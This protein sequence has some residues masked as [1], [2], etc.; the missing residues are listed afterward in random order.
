[1]I[2]NVVIVGGGAA[3]WIVAN[4]IK[5]Y[6]TN[7]FGDYTVN[8]TLVE[9]LGNEPLGIGEGTTGSVV[10]VL[11]LFGLDLASVNGTLKY[12]INYAGWCS[13]APYDN[14]YNPFYA[15]ED[16]QEIFDLFGG[17][18]ESVF[19]PAKL[20][21][22]DVSKTGWHLEVSELIALL[23]ARSITAGCQHIVG[24]VTDCLLDSAGNIESVVLADGTNLQADLYV[25]CS[26]FSQV[27]VSKL[28]STFTDHSS[29][30]LCDSAIMT[31]LPTANTESF[32]WTKATALDAGWVWN[33]PLKDKTSTGYV[34]SSQFVSDIQAKAEFNQHLGTDQDFSVVRW[35]D[36]LLD[37]SF[38][39]NCVAIGLSSCFV[40]PLE[41][42]SLE[43]IC[44]LA[45]R[46][47]DMLYYNKV[48]ERK[49]DF[50]SRY[51]F[52]KDLFSSYIFFRYLLATKNDTDF[53]AHVT[54]LVVPPRI[55]T[56]LEEAQPGLFNI[57]GNEISVTKPTNW[58][59]SLESGSNVL[60]WLYLCAGVGKDIA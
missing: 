31:N 34:Y 11:K 39:K 53:W 19:D 40:E 13:S 20:N 3:G 36:R 1:M 12:G 48:Q 16:S 21:H 52:S 28:G 26:G 6:E 33:I 59:L 14:H 5:Y 24:E 50:N 35:S 25:D 49:S 4:A 55:Q 58:N 57:S 51:R 30:L 41:A 2:K 60:Y 32:Y 15:Y 44:D 45:F 38:K 43:V 9:S 56:F 29:G 10:R 18:F 54:S 7:S 17:S 37:E 42:T 23:K 46:V 27:L 8:I 47:G 22:Q